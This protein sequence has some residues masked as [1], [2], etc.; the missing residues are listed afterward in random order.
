MGV[1]V[2]KISLED[3]SKDESVK[4]GKVMNDR[5]TTREQIWLGPGSL[6]K[7]A[8][9]TAKSV[10]WVGTMLAWILVGAVVPLVAQQAAAP[11][12]QE[13]VLEGIPSAPM[14][15]LDGA[16]K[17]VIAN[18]L[19]ELQTA[20]AASPQDPTQIMETFGELGFL[21]HAHELLDSA[22][23]CYNNA[24]RMAPRD[25][26]WSYALALALRAKGDLE[27]AAAAYEANL[28]LLPRNSTALVGLAE[29]RLEQNMPLV[30]K[31]LLNHAL[32]LS[33]DSPAALAV[34]G[35]VALSTKDYD[36]AVNYFERALQ[37]VPEANRLHYPLGLAYRGLGDVE[38]ARTH[39]EQRGDV[40]LRAPDPIFDAIEERKTGER[41]MIL[42][43]RRAFAVGRYA[44]AATSFQ[45][46][47]QSNPES[48]A[49]RVNLATALGAGGDVQAAKEQYRQVLQIEPANSAA[50][51]NLGALLLQEGK[52]QEAVDL[53]KKAV[54][55]DS[56]DAES[57][58]QLARAYEMQEKPE[59]ALVLIRE[60]VQLNPADQSLW[61]SGRRLMTRLGLHG[62]ARTWLEEAYRAMPD[63]G[64]I[65]LEL[66][67]LMSTSP[68]PQARD[69]EKAVSLA[70]RVASATNQPSHWLTL[71]KA[72]AEA[73]RCEEAAAVVRRLLDQAPE[74]SRE[75]LS[76]YLGKYEGG[77]P[78]RF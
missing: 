74:G 12:E 69:G 22:I 13:L 33:A 14:D 45:K 39:L 1:A 57:R 54:E 31:A 9:P 7:V 71:S 44:E 73:D 42:E 19:Q 66:A 29:V 52:T 41:V 23:A 77:S 46:A 63:Q 64:L 38:K 27:G 36:R 20:M 51:F 5:R 58:A 15:A 60:A 28:E 68:D 56:R 65:A 10:L 61:L 67:E 49:A 2:K 76:L 37:Q 4:K 55:S 34:L 70:T 53:L 35:Q 17:E 59:E 50:S 30:S 8:G 43:G 16:V 40:G 21:F 18:R 3:F 78:C 72:L 75:T 6:S 26:R 32:E 47:L 24:S 25:P 48:I 62:E 11:P